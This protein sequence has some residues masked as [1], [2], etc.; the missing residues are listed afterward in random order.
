M[1]IE[2][3]SYTLATITKNGQEAGKIDRPPQNFAKQFFFNAD[4]FCLEADEANIPFLV[5][6]VIAI[7]NLTD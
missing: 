4:S 1:S 6:V 7:D 2:F 5:A 3:N